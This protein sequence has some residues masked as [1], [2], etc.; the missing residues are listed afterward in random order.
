[1]YSK[2]ILPKHLLPWV[3]GAGIALLGL[4][5]SA[6]L[7][8]Q[9]VQSTAQL[10]QARLAQAANALTQ[11]LEG[12][13]D[14]YA[15]IAFGLRGLFIVNP[16]L[17]RNEFIDAVSTLGVESRYPGVKNIAF[18]RYVRAQDKAAFEA[19]VRGDTSVEPLGYPSFAIRPPGE[20][21]EYFVADY[22]WPQSGSK[23]VHGLDISAQP[24][25]LASMRYSKSSG[26]PV[27]SG[28]FD[29]IQETSHRTGFVIRVPVFNGV[30]FLGSVAVTLRVFDLFQ[31]LEREGHLRGLRL[32]LS[33]TGLPMYATPSA[34]GTSAVQEDGAAPHFQRT[35]SLFGR[36]WS[37]DF[38]PAQPFLS[39]TERRTPLMLGLAGALVS[40]LLGALVTSLS[41]GR[42]HA[43]T[44]AAASGEALVAERDFS[45]AV[46]NNAGA[47]VVVLDRGGRIQRFN[48]ESERVSGLSFTD[49]QGKFPWDTFLPPEIAQTVREQAFDALVNNPAQLTGSY[50]NEWL[51]RD[52][53]RRLID[54][55]NTVLLDAAGALE[56]VVA[57]GTDVTERNKIQVALEVSVREKSALLKEVHHRVKNNLQVITSLLRMEGRRSATADTRQVLAEMQGRIRSMAL[58]H[59]SLYRSGTLASVDLGAYLG[60]LAKQAFQAQQ[61]RPGGVRLTLALDSIAVGMDQAIPLG[62]LVNE[63]I[64]NCLKHAFPQDRTGEVRVTLQLDSARAHW[65]LCVADTG[66][67]LPPDFEVLRGQS[68]GLQLVDDLTL[69]LSGTME[70]ASQ[71]NAGATFSVRFNPVEPAPLVMPA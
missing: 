19:R 45:A 20:R 18:T 67:G 7:V 16:H 24:A 30:D 66:V 41:L 10:E 28:P 53:T 56:Y 54:W 14:A 8:R 4:V 65:C 61:V 40:L 42:M 70:V 9:Q 48:R 57:I 21:S 71:P 13:I 69:Q 29:L 58:L 59:E 60:D 37:L 36:T 38:H 2:S 3:F 63:L 49:V 26:Q 33:D 17:R 1:M 12:R 47:L 68:L 6:M 22:L 23:G 52:G 25:N 31:N 62:L 27:A 34:P 15:E 46:L 51:H 35:L 64:S 55:N 44:R 50:V 32:A 5:G 43:Q 39:E 11:A